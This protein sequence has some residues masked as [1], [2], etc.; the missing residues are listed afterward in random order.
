MGTSS[1]KIYKPS[2]GVRKKIQMHTLKKYFLWIQLNTILR[3]EMN[4]I[5]YS[6][7]KLLEP[8]TRKMLHVDVFICCLATTDKEFFK[9]CLIL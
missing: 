2:V 6:A 5:N 1:F 8:N 4:L 3:I 9:S 7:Y